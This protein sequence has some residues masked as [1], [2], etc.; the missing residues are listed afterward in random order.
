MDYL[1]YSEKLDYLKYCIQSR[2]AVTVTKL[3]LRLDVS[4]RTTLRMVDCLKAKGTNIT[5]C[6][7][8]KS[9]IIK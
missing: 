7:K 6:K 8:S 1:K 4:K 5:Y 9:Y 2:S 3:S